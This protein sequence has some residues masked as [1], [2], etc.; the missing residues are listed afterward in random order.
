VFKSRVAAF[1][2]VFAAILVSAPVVA[3]PSLAQAQTTAQRNNLFQAPPN[4]R[5]QDRRSRERVPPQTTEAPAL[6]LANAQAALTAAN[7][8]CQAT[9]AKFLGQL[10]GDASLYEAVC[11]SGPGYLV[12]TS[13]PPQ[14]VDC[15]IVS[16][17]AEAKRAEDPN[18]DVGTLCT[19]P[20]NVDQTAVYAGYA[21]QAGLTCR[22]DQGRPVGR[23]P[24]GQMIHEIGCAD[25]DGAW[26]E[27][28]DGAWTATPCLEVMATAGQCQFSTKQ[29]QI[30]DLQTLLAPSN[31]SDCVVTDLRPVGRNERGKYVEAKCA[32]AGDGYM[33]RIQEGVVQDVYHC[34]VAQP[35]AGGCR[36]TT[37]GAGA[38]AQTQR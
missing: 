7:T 30:S 38:A 29:E 27:M 37:V 33:A 20:A 34:N 11:A 32:A 26:V 13:T 17:S 14:A 16:A 24:G 35:I 21:R 36:L 25:A 19:L 5:S 23:S 8:D 2:G 22:V 9:E 28:K 18:A 6:S 1:C 15:I 3:I 31:A 12:I 10:E 4:R